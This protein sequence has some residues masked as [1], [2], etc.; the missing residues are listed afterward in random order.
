MNIVDAL[1]DEALFAPH[2]R[3]SSWDTWRAFLAA[4]FALPMTEAET[5][6]YQQY[7]GRTVTPVEPFREV[8]LVCGRRAGKSRMLALI[9]TYL[10][11]FRNYGPHLAPGERATVS[12]IASDRRQARGIYRYIV[13]M[14]RA[15]PMLE[16]LIV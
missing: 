7:T 14:F 16:D 2:F 13:G 8:A 3:G 6:L 4:T 11:V 5:A 1:D 9:A 15:V 12:V 10:S